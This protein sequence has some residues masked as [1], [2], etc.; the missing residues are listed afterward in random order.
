MCRFLTGN[1]A[2]Y[3]DFQVLHSHMC[4]HSQ[5]THLIVCTNLSR[6]I[7]GYWIIAKIAGN[8][9]NISLSILLERNWDKHQYIVYHHPEWLSP[10]NTLGYSVAHSDF[11]FYQWGFSNLIVLPTF[12]RSLISIESALQS[13][14][15]TIQSVFYHSPKCDGLC[16]FTPSLYIAAI[17]G[18]LLIRLLIWHPAASF[19]A[20]WIWYYRWM[21]TQRH[22]FT[23]D[24]RIMKSNFLS[25][26]SSL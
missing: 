10:Y 23:I 3:Y 17:T 20:G 25:W 15:S 4:F 19:F 5:N 16:T 6:K 1:K 22:Y 12:S 2:S 21:I 8:N 14:V 13:P 9:P 26:T 11:D 18:R 24:G 7:R